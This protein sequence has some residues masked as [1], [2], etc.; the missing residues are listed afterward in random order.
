MNVEGL[1]GGW[2]VGGGGG[3]VGVAVIS[4]N[5]CIYAYLSHCIYKQ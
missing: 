4:E 1:D 2:G 3:G 5:K